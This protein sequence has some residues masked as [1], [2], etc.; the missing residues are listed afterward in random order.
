MSRAKGES[1]YFIWKPIL[2]KMPVPTM[3]AMTREAAV[4]ALTFTGVWSG[5]VI[6]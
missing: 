2:V 4:M 5:V 1:R 3:L 6:E